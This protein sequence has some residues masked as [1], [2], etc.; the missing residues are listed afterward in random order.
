MS[1]QTGVLKA[2]AGGVPLTA[3]RESLT[4]DA[5]RRLIRN[6]AAVMGGVIVLCR[7]AALLNSIRFFNSSGAVPVRR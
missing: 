7:L 4:A 5:F 2:G 6:R 3:K 1:A